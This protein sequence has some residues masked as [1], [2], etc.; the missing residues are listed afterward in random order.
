ML[1]DKKETGAAAIAG[2]G[3]AH[4]YGAKILAE[5]IEDDPANYTR[6]FL[7]GRDDP[8]L[9][10]LDEMMVK[11]ELGPIK[12]SIA[13]YVQNAPGNLYDALR[14]F[15]ERGIDLT[16]V[17][18]R[19]VRGKPFEYLF[20]LDFFGTPTTSPSQEAIA[21]LSARAGFLR[22]LGTY[23]S[24]RLDWVGSEAPLL[25]RAETPTP[26]P[27]PG[28]ERRESDRRRVSDRRRTPLGGPPG[29]PPPLPG[30]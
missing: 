19:P 27:Y 6:F 2:R 23:P 24:G 7:L 28:P 14:G 1:I 30:V 9:M 22:I 13:F 12:T 15:A 29:A 5:G 17:E 20:Y 11:E 21:D 8:D 10:G 25:P 4:H 16:R 26:A 3:A 18:S